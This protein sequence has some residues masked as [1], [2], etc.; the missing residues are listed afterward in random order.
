MT[1][2]TASGDASASPN[3]MSLRAGSIVV[4][5]TLGFLLLGLAPMLVLY[6]ILSWRAETIKSVALE[7]L[8][9]AAVTLNLAAG[10][11]LF[12]RYVDVKGFTV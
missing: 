4:R 11:E 12:Q 5:L 6:G 7:R 1:V 2:M 3:R 8:K 10:Q 9:D